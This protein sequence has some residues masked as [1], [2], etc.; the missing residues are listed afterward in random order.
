MKAN[1]DFATVD[2][3]NP[4]MARGIDQLLV[5]YRYAR[6]VHRE[7]WDFAV[8]IQSLRDVG[9]NNSEIRWLIAKELV[10]HG[11][12]QQGS[13][14][15]KKRVFR[16]VGDMKLLPRSCFVLTEQGFEACKQLSRQ[17]V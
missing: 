9:M 15:G 13:Q 11:E 7:Q 10:Q 16:T 5:A 2:V 1:V 4:G 3:L 14:S 17:P 12:E 8:E 6:E